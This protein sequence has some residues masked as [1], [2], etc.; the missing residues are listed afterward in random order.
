MENFISD[1][2]FLKERGISVEKAVVIIKRL[3]DSVTYEA[4]SEFYIFYKEVVHLIVSPSELDAIT[5]LI[6]N[7]E[8]KEEHYFYIL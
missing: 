7:T 2:P 1:Y 4:F 8:Q 5:G 3:C 6:S